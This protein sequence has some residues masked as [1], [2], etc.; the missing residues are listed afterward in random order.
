[1]FIPVPK[2]QSVFHP[3]HE[4]LS[5]IAVRICNEARSRVGIHRCDAAPTPT[6]F[7]EIVS[8]DFP[9]IH[10]QRIPARLLY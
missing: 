3:N 7:A 5:V 1:L 8:D 6:G 2:T 10:A 4:T 9:V